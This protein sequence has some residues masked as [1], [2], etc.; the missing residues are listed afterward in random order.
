[1][2]GYRTFIVA[3]VLFVAPAFARWGLQIDPYIVADAMLIIGP[4]V[5]ALMRAITTT[6][7]GVKK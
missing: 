7:A 4:A 2:Q 5:M 3:A 6:P 1:M